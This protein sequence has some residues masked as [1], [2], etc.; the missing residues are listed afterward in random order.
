[1][2]KLNLLAQ[3]AN[4][5]WPNGNEPFQMTTRLL[6]ECGEVAS[7]VNL[8]ENSGVKREKH[9]IPQK[10][11]LAKEIMQSMRVLMQIAI[12]YSVEQELDQ[13][14]EISL[15]NMRQDGLID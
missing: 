13:S 11:N 4:K 9:G 8:R 10:A 6:E 7:E 12:Y 5:R 2:Q 14:I 3:G 15:Q 1:M